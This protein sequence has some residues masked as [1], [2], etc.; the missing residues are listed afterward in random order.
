[1]PSPNWI[2]F[3]LFEKRNNLASKNPK[4]ANFLRRKIAQ[5]FQ[6]SQ[7]QLPVLYNP[8]SFFFLISYP[9]NPSLAF[10]ELKTILDAI[11]TPECLSDYPWTTSLVVA[12]ALQQDASLCQK[13]PGYR[14][15]SALSGLFRL[16]IP[17][18]PPRL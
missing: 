10:E 11:R 17:A 14:L 18:T 7:V 15:I 9:L 8:S 12:Q 2:C 5:G 16:M 3:H 1:M 6:G 4:R 13:A